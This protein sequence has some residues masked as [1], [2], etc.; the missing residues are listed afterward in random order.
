VP[1]GGIDKKKGATLVSAARKLCAAIVALTKEGA[2]LLEDL[3]RETS[4]SVSRARKS[5]SR[6]VSRFSC[7]RTGVFHGTLAELWPRPGVDTPH[8]GIGVSVVFFSV[9]TSSK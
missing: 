9:E 4:E 7:G 8:G 3:L 1:T 2:T 5:G 6:T